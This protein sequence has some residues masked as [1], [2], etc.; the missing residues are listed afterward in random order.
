MENHL[1]KGKHILLDLGE[2]DKFILNDLTEL[3]H[4]LKTACFKSKAKI[5]G[6]RFKIF[7]P[8]G[9][10]IIFLLAESHVSIHTYPESG[11]AFVDFF[12]CGDEGFPEIGC[13][14][15]I[16]R[17]KANKIEKRIIERVI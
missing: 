8:Q 16:D 7:Q 13:N 15:I 1:A 4:I 6:K 17:L 9:I 3:L 11:K 14:L 12:T 2:C 10:S 5:V